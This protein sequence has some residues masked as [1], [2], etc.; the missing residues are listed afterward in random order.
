MYKESHSR[1]QKYYVS[2]SFSFQPLTNWWLTFG[3]S[4]IYGDKLEDAYKRE[5]TEFRSL[6]LIN[7]GDGSFESKELP[8]EAQLFPVMASVFTDINGDGY[9]DAILAGNIYETEV[10]TPRLDAI[11]GL[12][13]LS[14]GKDGYDP[15]PYTRTGLYL[16]GNVKDLKW[17]TVNGKQYLVNTVN[18]G[19]LALNMMFQA[20]PEI[21]R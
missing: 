13:L 4:I 16:K 15:Q 18:D 5:A 6:L 14:N 7:K 3:E 19:P 12:V 17:I 11:S 9:E 21:S 20:K 8:V 2:H 1:L 10:E